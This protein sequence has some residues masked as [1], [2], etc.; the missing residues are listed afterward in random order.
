MRTKYTV[1]LNGGSTLTLLIGKQNPQLDTLLRQNQSST[2]AYLTACNPFSSTLSTEENLV[3]HNALLKDVS[4]LGYTHLVGLSIPETG[5]WDPEICI[6]VFNMSR[7][8]TRE[9]CQK[10]DQDAAL[11]GD[12]GSP[13]KL[14]F[15]NPSLREDFINL[16]HNCVLE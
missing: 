13:P 6:F 10:Y 9:L 11:V 3:R 16:L 2:Y 4:D 7:T 15:T 14:F 1:H 12:W 8:V 5:D